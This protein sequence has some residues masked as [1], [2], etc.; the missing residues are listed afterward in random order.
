MKETLRISIDER[1]RLRIS[2]LIKG[3]YISLKEAS[4]KLGISYSQMKR[5]VKRYREECEEGIVHRSRGHKSNRRMKE[6]IRYY[7]MDLWII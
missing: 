2:E 5:I 4:E 1:K 3:K 6:K 7:R